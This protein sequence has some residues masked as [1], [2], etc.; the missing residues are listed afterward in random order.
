MPEPPPGESNGRVGLDLVVGS[1][2][3]DTLLESVPDA[4]VGV[5]GGGR[6][7]LANSHVGLFGYGHQELVGEPI[8]QLVPGL[9][10]HA[11]RKDGSEFPAEISVSPLQTATGLL[12]AAVIRDVTERSESN[13]GGAPPQ[14]G[15]AHRGAVARPNRELGVGRGLGAGRLIRRAVPH[16]RARARRDRADLEEFLSRVHPSDRES[17]DERNRKAFADHE[18]F[19]DVKRIVRL[20]GSVFLIRT[21]GEVIADDEGNPVRMIR[22]CEDV[23]GAVR[24]DEAHSRLAAIVTSSDD[25]IVGHTALGMITSWNPGAER[26][27]GYPA[28]EAIGRRIEMLLPEGRADEELRILEELREGVRVDP[29]ETQRVRKN[30]SLVAVSLSVSP[31]LGPRGQVEGV[32]S[33][34]RDVTERRR[35][36]ARLRYLADHDAQTRPPQPPP[37]RG[38]AGRAGGPRGALRTRECR[39][40]HRFVTDAET[41]ARMRDLGVDYAQGYHVGRP[42]PM[43][44][45]PARLAGAIAAGVY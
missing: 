2:V 1:H 4:V 15:A 29:Y 35:F 7:A 20:D 32:C 34:A 44:E 31:A 28:E 19:E 9:D 40:G 21:K 25:A 22:V 43:A 5:D 39:A 17:V 6:I 24:A 37:L 36:E 18:P 11:R 12:V 41:V 23:T 38:G 3:G 10:S 16:L 13:R 26:L 45:L 42:F 14:Q 27:Y 33:I 8:K 30:G